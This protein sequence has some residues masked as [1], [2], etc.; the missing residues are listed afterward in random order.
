MFRTPL[1]NADLS[2]LENLTADQLIALFAFCM[3]QGPGRMGPGQLADAW[4]AL[5]SDLYLSAEELVD[6]FRRGEQRLEPGDEQ[7]LREFIAEDCRNGGHVVL[8]IIRKGGRI[9]RAALIIIANLADIAAIETG[10]TTALHLL[11]EACDKTVRQSL[12]RSAG[13]TLLSQIYDQRGIPVIFSIYGLGDVGV[14][15]LDAIAQVFSED[16][17]KSV[18]CRNRTGK[19]AFTV[20]SEI[21]R[22]LKSRPAMERHVFFKSGAVRNADEDQTKP[23]P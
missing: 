12:I 23:S 4:G 19:D 7:I 2:R 10:G 13:K 8:N 21:A 22:S 11:A 6:E 5:F 14:R 20:F 3:K 15:D 16:E 17:L 9:D 18:M 1:P